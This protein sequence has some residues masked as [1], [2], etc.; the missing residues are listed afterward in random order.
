MCNLVTK[1]SHLSFS[2]IWNNFSKKINW[3]KFL[4]SWF[5]VVWKMNGL[6]NYV[7]LWNL[8]SKI[9]W[10]THF[11]L[12]IK[13]FVQDH[14]S[15]DIFPFGDVMKDWQDK[16]QRYL[17]DVWIFL[18]IFILHTNFKCCCT[19]FWVQVEACIQASR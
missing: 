14:Y 19:L 10:Q 3:W 15:M 2:V 4:L 16:K 12:V 18:H 17:I 6:L 7:F 8:S 5:W 11:D 1:M 13:M 9:D